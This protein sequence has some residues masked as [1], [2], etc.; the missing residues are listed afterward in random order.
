[1][2]LFLLV[3]SFPVLGVTFSVLSILECSNHSGEGRFVLIW[4]EF[5]R[6]IRFRQ[7]ERK[8]IQWH[9]FRVAGGPKKLCSEKVGKTA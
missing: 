2:L 1:M 5:R 7:V 9:F 4:T 6:R 8:G 3:I